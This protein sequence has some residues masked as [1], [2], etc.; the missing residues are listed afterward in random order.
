MGTT[1]VWGNEK[2]LAAGCGREALSWFSL[3]FSRAVD[4]KKKLVNGSTLAR[5]VDEGIYHRQGES[6]DQAD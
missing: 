5:L 2:G 3:A 1:F 4:H 6:D